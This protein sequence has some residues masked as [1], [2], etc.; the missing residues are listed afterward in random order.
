MADNKNRPKKRTA[1]ALE[2][3]PVDSAPKVIASGTGV[4]AD[5]IIE[6][7]SPEN[8]SKLMSESDIF[9]LDI[10]EIMKMN[11]SKKMF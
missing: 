2:Y 5:K 11:A 4:I 9:S 1:V 7:A 3:D 10:E 8:M 6:K